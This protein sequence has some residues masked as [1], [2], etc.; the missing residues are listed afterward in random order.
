MMVEPQKLPEPWSWLLGEQ[1]HSSAHG[2]DCNSQDD[3]AHD[4]SL[5]TRALHFNAEGCRLQEEN[6]KFALASTG[7]SNAKALNRGFNR[8]LQS[9]II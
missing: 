5:D 2:Y 6:E 8:R 3:S 9:S 1:Q 4:V 7:T